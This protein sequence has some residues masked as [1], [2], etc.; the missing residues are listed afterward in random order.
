LQG[1][2]FVYGDI[3]NLLFKLS[4]FITFGNID[5]TIVLRVGS[6]KKENL[7]IKT[8]LPHTLQKST[9]QKLDEK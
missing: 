8:Y 9:L 7:S 6:I 1:G 4:C 5:I 3:F 2:K